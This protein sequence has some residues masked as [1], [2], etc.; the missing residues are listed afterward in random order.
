VIH[1][2]FERGFIAAEIVSYTDLIQAQSLAAARA[3]GKVRTEGKT[4]IMQPDDIVEFR[5]NVS[6]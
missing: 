1:G 4:Y 3:A 2:D 6:K 5:F